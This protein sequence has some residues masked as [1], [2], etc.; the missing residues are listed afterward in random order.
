MF[1]WCVCKK[2]KKLFL[3]IINFNALIGKIVMIK[4]SNFM[5]KLAKNVQSYALHKKLSPPIY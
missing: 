3:F 2:I 5:Q 1:I 4:E